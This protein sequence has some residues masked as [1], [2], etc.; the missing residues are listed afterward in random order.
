[1]L[2][3]ASASHAA[4]AVE[5]CEL[6][7]E[8]VNPANGNTTA[9]KTG[10]MKCVER[11]TGKLVREQ[12][13][14]AGVFVGLVRYYKD[15]VLFKEYSV[16]E[17]GNTHGKLREFAPNGQVLLEENN[18]NGSTRGFLHEWY[19]NGVLKRVAFIGEK[20]REK[21]AVRYTPNKQLSELECA[22]KALLAPHVDDA[23]LC[24]FQGK[25]SVVQL[26][27][28]SGKL[29]S[30][31]TIL[32]GMTQQA[33][34]FHDNGK[35]ETVD[36]VGSK[37]KTRKQYSDKGILRKET[38]WNTTGKPAAVEREVE[39]HESGSKVREQIFAII[40]KD[41]R[42]QNRLQSDASFYLNGQPKSAEK[43]SVEGKNEIKEARYYF[44]NGQLSRLE[45]YI[46][47]GRYRERP[48]GTHQS[49]AQNGK[50]VRESY[51]DEAGRIERERSWDD[52]GKLLSDEQVFEDG[53]R[54]AYTK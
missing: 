26:F 25:S 35:P 52:S 23:V 31:F 13:L 44:D 21:A 12:E 9:G 46:V 51:Y 48:L 54:K 19:A 7:R 3:L 24:G 20:P 11:D 47:E 28:D 50:L 5:D 39:Y 1:M 15:G 42:R 17:A 30:Q 41:G 36:E 38:V 8:S 2:A 34:Y 45:R 29:R 6:N 37:Q 32:A 10:I 53:S 22:E 4:M 33:S 43:F 40:E 49:Y 18:V 14:R 27:S 16:N